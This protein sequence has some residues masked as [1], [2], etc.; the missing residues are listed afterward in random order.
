ME[1]PN[2][3]N[4]ASFGPEASRTNYRLLSQLLADM[5]RQTWARPFLYPINTQAHLSAIR[6]TMDLSTMAT[7]LNTGAY[8]RPEDFIK[9]AEKIFT[10]GRSFRRG[11]TP[12]GINAADLLECTVRLE[13]F[14]WKKSTRFRNSSTSSKNW[15]SQSV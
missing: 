8:G 15:T 14:M 2:T 6:D 13:K 4:D 7:K 10:G 5:Q 3:P 9:D 12:Y 11:P 1:I